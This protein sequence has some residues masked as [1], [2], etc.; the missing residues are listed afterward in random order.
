LVSATIQ[1]VKKLKKAGKKP[2][3]IRQMD[4]IKTSVYRALGARRSG[5]E[6]ANVVHCE[7]WS[8]TQIQALSRWAEG[9]SA[10]C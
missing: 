6:R 9:Y 1:E 8:A 7:A 3:I 4:L 2:E 10:L 5:R